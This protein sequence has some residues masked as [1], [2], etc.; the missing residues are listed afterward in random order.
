MIEI[1]KIGGTPAPLVVLW[2]V[3]HEWVKYPKHMMTESEIDSYCT[4]QTL[5]NRQEKARQRRQAK[6]QP[7]NV[8]PD[9]PSKT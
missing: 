3:A 9:G 2:G 5:A 7:T 6:A 1:Q 4:M 8:C